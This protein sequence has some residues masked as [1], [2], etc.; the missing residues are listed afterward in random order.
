MGEPIVVYCEGVGISYPVADGQELSLLT[1]L[2]MENH[3]AVE[4]LEEVRREAR[5]R[6][7]DPV[8]RFPAYLEE[9]C[10]AA[11]LPLDR[12]SR[13]PRYSFEG[14]FFQLNVD[15]RSGQARL[16]DH[17]GR[18]AELPSD[19]D[20]IAEVVKREHARVFGRTF[21]GAKFLAKLRNQYLAIVKK[22]GQSDGL[23]VPIRRITQWLGKNEKRFRTDEFLVDLSRLVVN[24][25][26]EIG[27]WRLD[28][29]QTK[30]TDQG[31]LL[32][33]AAGSGY[34]GFVV[35][36]KVDS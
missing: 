17:E 7:D 12:A 4:Q 35:F 25:P 6:A 13:H 10:R 9:P 16:S 28:L 33:G 34:V 20:A 23:V 15:E 21:D 24:G 3:P 26:I 32:H 11:A 1:Q 31:M 2:K 30:D 5:K 18:L 19:P 22:D 29:Q 14:G 36:R 8:R 27:G